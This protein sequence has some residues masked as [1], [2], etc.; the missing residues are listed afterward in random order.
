[1]AS[2]RERAEAICERE[3]ISMYRLAQLLRIAQI[4]LSQ[5]TEGSQPM[6]WVLAICEEQ[7]LGFFEAKE[8]E[9]GTF[10]RKRT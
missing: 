5:S 7:G 2:V 8:K 9:L 3:G 6:Q 10:G 4:A 1:M